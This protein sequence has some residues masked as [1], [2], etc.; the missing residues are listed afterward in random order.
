MLGRSD[1]EIKS[2]RNIIKA[3]LESIGNEVIDSIFAENAP[4]T[5]QQ[6]AWYLGKA[7]QLLA[8]AD[9]AYFVNGWQNARGCRLEHDICVAYDIPIYKD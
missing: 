6:G 2:E 7:V 8:T 1:E 3:G 9:S 5:S 4:E